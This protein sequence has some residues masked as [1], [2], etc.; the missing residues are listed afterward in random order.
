[1]V[2]L[3]RRPGAPFGPLIKL[4]DPTG[5]R[6][7]EVARMEWT[8]LDLDARMWRLPAARSKNGK[9]HNVP[10]NDPAVEILEDF[11]L[12]SKAANSR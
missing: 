9:A 4:L 7:D 5:A 2:G 12:A 11:S 10:L 8:E 3:R 1:M 6:R